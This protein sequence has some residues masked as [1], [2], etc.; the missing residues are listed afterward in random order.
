MTENRSLSKTS[1]EQVT[2]CTNR[3]TVGVEPSIERF[4]VP[5]NRQGA[6]GD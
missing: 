5:S 2:G 1:F 4:E 3:V 6:M